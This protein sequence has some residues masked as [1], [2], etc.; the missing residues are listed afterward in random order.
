MARPDERK[1]IMTGRLKLFTCVLLSSLVLAS[2]ALINAQRNQRAPERQIM[3][4]R[5]R[6]S[7]PDG[8]PVPPPDDNFMFIASEMNFDG[9][10]VKGSPYSAQAVTERNQTL[11]DGNHIV[12][13]STASVYRDGQGRTRREQSLIGMAAFTAAG[14]SPQTI[15]INDPV[16]GVNYALDSHTHV[17][18]KMQP[19]R[20]ELKSPMPQ[21]EAGVRV[22]G[23]PPSPEVFESATPA[24]PP[25]GGVGMVFGWVGRREENSK[26][27]SLGKQ[28]IEGVEA[29]GTRNTL[30]ISAGEIGNE[31]PIEIVF[32][33]WYS[34]DLQVV[35]MTRHSDPRFGETVYRLTNISRS[36]PDPTL[37]EVPADYK[38]REGLPT[39]GSMRMKRRGI[40]E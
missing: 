1:D 29:E 3:I 25:E 11:S 16:A 28:T 10:L 5:D 7:G 30:E 33:R 35:V 6:I 18:H 24:P 27:E 12:N 23:P 15:F 32:E 38:V 20:L 21:A 37:F 4:E 2:A 36:E 8:P 40:P 22:A 26:T 9:K 31:K 39:P 19:M 13:K 14:G 17:A 34:P